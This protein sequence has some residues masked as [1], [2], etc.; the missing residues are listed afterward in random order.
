MWQRPMSQ[1][2]GWFDALEV[3]A[4]QWENVRREK[5]N[6]DCEMSF[7][8]PSL[9]GLDDTVAPS[10]IGEHEQC[11]SKIERGFWGAE[12]SVQDALK[13]VKVNMPVFDPAKSEDDGCRR[14][15]DELEEAMGG[16]DAQRPV[17]WPVITI[18][19]SKKQL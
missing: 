4:S 16:S 2:H 10:A 3:P 8:S 18:L 9:G 12:W 6:F 19:A 11:L 1:I 7:F 15:V 5:T 14:L 17:C 13:F